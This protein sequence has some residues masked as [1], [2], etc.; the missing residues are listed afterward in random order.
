MSA[1]DVI[2]GAVDEFWRTT[3]WP[4]NAA[5]KAAMDALAAAGFAVVPQADVDAAAR[6]RAE[7]D[8]LRELVRWLYDNTPGLLCPFDK[9]DLALSI[10]QAASVGSETPEP[11][12]CPACNDDGVIHT[13]DGIALGPCP[14]C[15]RPDRCPTCG[16]DDPEVPGVVGTEDGW[17]VDCTHPWHSS[18]PDR[19]ST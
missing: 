4:L 3:G 12:P 2:A 7:N 8:E 10:T 14:E 16:S 6:L 18:D 13:H 15:A 11:Q 17:P 9:L 1:E 5:G 19:G